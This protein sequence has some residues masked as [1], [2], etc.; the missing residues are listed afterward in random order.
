MSWWKSQKTFPI[1]NF[2]DRADC[3]IGTCF[4]PRVIWALAW[5]I[6]SSTICLARSIA[7]GNGY[8]W[9]AEADLPTVLP[10]LKLDLS[11]I[12]YD[13]R[14]VLTSFRPPLYPAFL[15]LVYLVFGVGTHRFFF[16]RLIQTILG[17]L[18]AP[19]T[20]ALARKTI[21]KS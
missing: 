17:A 13:P 3:A 8:R 4:E 21:S 19:L 14:G 2:P 20:F 9:Y 15:A 6:C 7:A 18:L 1:K 5:T 16:A 10:Y 12:N 11:S